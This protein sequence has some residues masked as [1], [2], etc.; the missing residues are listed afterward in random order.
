MKRESKILRDHAAREIIRRDLGNNVMVL[1]G[2]GAGKTYALVER[3]VAAIRAGT[4]RV[5]RMAAITFTRKAA[6]EMRGRFYVQLRKELETVASDIEAER[7]RT[8]VAAIDQCFIGTIHAFCARMLR[9][10]PLEAGLAPDFT[11]LEEREEA[12]LR[13]ESWDSFV[14]RCYLRGDHRIHELNE[15]GI[16]PEDLFAFFV[17]RCSDAD[18]PLKETGTA[19]PALISLLPEVRSFIRAAAAHLPSGRVEPDDLMIALRRARHFIDNHGINTDRDAAILLGMFDG[20]VS[21]T[22]NRWSDRRAAKHIKEVLL[23]DFVSRVVEPGLRL[24]RESAYATVTSFVDEAVDFYA[25]AR[26]SKAVVTF[27]DLLIRTASMLREN[28]QVRAY[29]HRRFEAVFV[30]EFQDTDPIQAHILFFLTSTD[31]NERDWRKLRPRPGSLFLVGDDKQSIYRFRRADVEIFHFVADRIRE[32]GGQVVHLNTSFRSLGNLCSWI[33]SSFQPTFSGEG[34]PYQATFQP[35]F[36]HREAGNDLHCLRKI[37]IPKVER[38]RRADVAAIEADRV[39]GFI[40]A[41]LRG[42]ALS[43]SVGYNGSPAARPSAGDFLILTRT[44]GQISV[45]TRALEAAGIPFDVA[46]GGRLGSAEAVEALVCLLEA[47]YEPDNPVP[48]ISFLRGPLVGLSDAELY[49]IRI[50]GGRFYIGAPPPDALDAELRARL[51]HASEHLAYAKRCL[52]TLSPAAAV[53]RIVDRL[54]ILSFSAVHPDGGGSTRAGG[55]VRLISHIRNLGIRGW[56]WGRILED[57]R[58]VVRDES[59]KLE[60]MTLELGRSDVVRVMNVHQAKGLQAPVVF[61]VD[62]CD[63]S[64][65]RTPESHVCRTG[66][67][68]YLSMV[69]TKPRGNYESEVLAQPEGWEN[70]LAEENRFALAEETRLLYVAATR[71]RD[72]LVVSQYPA[73]PKRGPWSPLYKFLK[74]VPELPLFEQGSQARPV[75]SN[76]SFDG[77]RR[78]S[79][80]RIA[81]SK[82]STYGVRTVSALSSEKED[83]RLMRDGR[84][85]D[86]GVIMHRLFEEAVSDRLPSNPEPYVRG[87]IDQ[88]GLAGHLVEDAVSALYR[89]RA[90]ALWREMRRSERVYTEVPVGGNETE[91]GSGYA[92]RGVIDLV[93]KWKGGWRIIDY[94]TD[95]ATSEEELELLRLKYMP[96][97]QEYANFWT[98]ATGDPV[99]CEFWFVHGPDRVEQL[100]LF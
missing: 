46:G 11:E 37:T 19:R 24:W 31:R 59:Y 8:A 62:A 78:R 66:S 30:D 64:Y 45:F 48:Y 63:S 99:E 15:H 6:G 81:R 90:S 67:E 87:L 57:L 50:A 38:N 40:S 41:A 26:E 20:S 97:V 98:R 12:A 68:A 79:A 77:V 7:L 55:I 35:L 73:G 72:L 42:D 1:A 36:E 86:Y 27:H 39:A 22:L 17:R 80:D 94:K 43:W 54:G 28:T 74:N 16:T 4:A 14:E 10:R 85:R 93:F 89:F 2:A 84:G 65:E 13:R 9:E 58:E 92:I 71:A 32:T 18:L 75:E 49:D 34:A 29:F 52:T 82:E 5:N 70:D 100:A 33:N 76:E 61:L 91:G 25:G 56:N 47:V 21:Q 23:P 60:E 83:M 95:A 53:E 3:M 44:T 88:A 69:V 51:D 96:Q